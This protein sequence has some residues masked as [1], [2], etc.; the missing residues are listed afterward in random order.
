MSVLTTFS[1]PTTNTLLR[2]RQSLQM[3]HFGASTSTI[4]ELLNM[5]PKLAKNE[6]DLVDSS[7][8]KT[9]IGK[10]IS[11]LHRDD[12]HYEIANKL[13]LYYAT[14]THDP[15]VQNDRVNIDC[16]LNAYAF[17]KTEFELTRDI[18][19]RSMVNFNRFLHL[20]YRIKS[21]NVRVMTCD[22]GAKYLVRYDR[23]TTHCFHCS[24]SMTDVE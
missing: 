16:M 14:L 8:S 20:L 10:N 2:E 18:D 11:F 7:F 1:R 17:V 6:L 19:I 23:Y 12:E 13:W 5:V 22:C 3:V 9:R 4:S 21:G 24:E 15:E